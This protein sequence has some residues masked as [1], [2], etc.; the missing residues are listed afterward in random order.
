M[1]VIISIVVTKKLAMIGLF[2]FRK[3]AKDM[4]KKYN[5]KKEKCLAMCL[6]S[7]RLNKQIILKEFR[8]SSIGEA[9]EHVKH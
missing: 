2:L 1:F 7:H 4:M 8:K 9:L 5:S 6:S 3:K